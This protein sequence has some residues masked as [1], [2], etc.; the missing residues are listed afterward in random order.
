MTRAKHPGKP[1]LY[2]IGSL[3]NPRVPEVAALIREAGFEAFDNWFSGGERADDAWK[4]YERGRGNDY[5]SALANHSARHTF[6]FDQFHLNRAHGAVMVLPAGRSAHLEAGLMS[7]TKPVFLLQDVEGEPERLDV[8]TRF[9]HSVH[10]DAASLTAGLKAYRWPRLLDLP[11]HTV[12]DAVWLA[13]VFEGDGT[14]CI[15]DG[16][17][18]M[19]LQ[20]TDEDVV[21]HAAAILG[22][23]VCQ[24]STTV[25]GKKVYSC[26]VTG[27]RAAEWMRVVRPYMGQRR[28]KQIAKTV[29][30]WLDNR[31]YHTADTAWWERVFQLKQE[32][33]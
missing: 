27:L 32:R 24:T 5:K 6:A 30:T 2:V 11:F 28:Q 22:A 29:R 23:S 33:P 26:G 20:M 3:R 18:R 19:V 1:V 17:A 14:F 25:A 15:T 16:N 4:D 8:M 9:L 21:A 7:A 10:A 31:R 12:L 13:G